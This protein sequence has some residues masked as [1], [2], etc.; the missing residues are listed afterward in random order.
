M[1]ILVFMGWIGNGVVIYIF[2]MTPFLR[3]PSN[4]LVI[5]LAFSDFIVMIIM[6]PPMV[7]NCYYETWVL[8]PLMCDI[9]AMVGSLCGC[10]S[11]WTMTAIALDRYNVIVKDMAGKP[12]TIKKALLEILLIWIFALVWTILSMVG[13]NSYV[14]EGNMTAC[15]TDYLIK[16]WSSKFYILMYSIFVYYTP[17]FTIIYSY[18]FI[19]SAVSAHEKTMRE[20]AKKMN[21][22]PLRSGDNQNMSAEAK[23]AKVALM[24]ISLWFMAWTPYLVINYIGIFGGASI[25]PLSTIWGSLFAKANAIYNPI[26]YG[27]R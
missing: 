5:N 10:A 11:I 8:G 3:T 26:V 14:P 22:Q 6:S 17:L 20:Q 23:L 2:L 15:G 21:V 9:Y 7:I 27:I 24:T 25:S 13:W 1:V 19:V 4:L 16:D 12:L 18:Y